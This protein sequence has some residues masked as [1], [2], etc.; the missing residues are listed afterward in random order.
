MARLS[1]GKRGLAGAAAVLLAAS[2]QAANLFGSLQ[3][4]GTH[5]GIDQVFGA[6]H[7]LIRWRD[8]A[9]GEPWYGNGPG[10]RWLPS[11]RTKGGESW[12]M[13]ILMPRGFI[14]PP[15]IN[16]VVPYW[17]IAGAGAGLLWW[18]WRAHR[19]TVGRCPECRYDLTGNVVGRC[20]ECGTVVDSDRNPL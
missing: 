10:L 18:G 14:N 5:H 15:W 8:P 3:W 9:P 11:S 19:P 13:H 2:L 7:V 1:L 20:P 4:E 17:M 6:V 12:R 16:I